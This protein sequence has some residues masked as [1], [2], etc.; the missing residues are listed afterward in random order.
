MPPRSLDVIEDHGSV[1]H[2]SGEHGM[3]RV[4]MPAAHDDP[5]LL[6]TRQADH[7]TRRQLRAG[8]LHARREAVFLALVT[9][10]LVATCTVLF[11]GARTIDLVA[12]IAR[13]VDV[14]LPIAMLLP[15]GA[16]ALPITFIVVALVSELYGRRRAMALVIAGSFASLA[17]LGIVRLADTATLAP[18][19]SLASCYVV[20]HVAHVLLFDTFR[21]RMLHR[22]FWLRLDL[23][24]LLAQLGGWTAFAF[25]LRGTSQTSDDVI[26][27]LALGGCAYTVI[28]VLA[29]TLPTLLAAKLLAAQLRIAADELVEPGGAWA[30]TTTRINVRLPEPGPAA[31]PRASR[32]SGRAFSHAEMQFFSEGDRLDASAYD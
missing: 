17:T 30:T 2:L 26:R 1:L 15:A 28:A 12:L 29:A 11:T 7:P 14:E 22:H 6:P 27:S 4:A 24:T 21:Q 20:A 31:P 9:T 19:L 5:W 25:V 23:A 8:H 32:D 18:S 16:V 13:V 3:L 10:F